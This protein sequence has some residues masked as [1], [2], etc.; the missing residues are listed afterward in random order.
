MKINN[1]IMAGISESW[2]RGENGGSNMA[3][4]AAAI[5]AAKMA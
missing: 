2:R 4:M 1:E 3:S 5:M